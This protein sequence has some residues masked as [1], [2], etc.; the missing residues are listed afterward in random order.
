M[1]AVGIQLV[2]V[3]LYYWHPKVTVVKEPGEGL[4]KR[5]VEG[6]CSNALEN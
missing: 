2:V 5:D 3:I 6:K 1:A 4:G